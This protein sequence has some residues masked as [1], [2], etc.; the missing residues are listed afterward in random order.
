MTI[1][2]IIIS[3]TSRMRRRKTIRYYSRFP[4]VASARH[5]YENV[6]SIVPARAT[7]LRF[8]FSTPRFIYSPEIIA[9]RSRLLF[10]CRSRTTAAADAFR[11]CRLTVE[12]L[13][14]RRL[15]REI[16][17]RYG[18]VVSRLAVERK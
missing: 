17:A 8:F 13:P 18:D 3:S 15:L 9:Y 1:I 6:I 11:F 12:K 2:T 4:A 5:A 7:V 14:P 10:A 16:S